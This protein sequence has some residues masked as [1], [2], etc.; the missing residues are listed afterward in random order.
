MGKVVFS[1][2]EFDLAEV[3]YEDWKAIHRYASLP[4]VSQYQPWE[5]MRE[6]DTTD[7]VKG[8]VEA[9]Q[10]VPRTRFAYAIQ[11][12][13]RT[14]GVT[15][16]NVRD[17]TNGEISYILHP[18]YWGQGL[19]TK[20]AKKMLLYGFEELELHRI[21][22]TCDPNNGASARV[23]QRLGMREEGRLRENLWSKDHWRDS[24]LFSVLVHECG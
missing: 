3:V 13:R 16:L 12:D 6:K 1:E 24:L 5:T 8:I 15:E 18:D 2:A 9:A 14:I 10:Q 20:A 23:L 22:G 11:K 4:I 21:Y 17:K 7:Y 19:A